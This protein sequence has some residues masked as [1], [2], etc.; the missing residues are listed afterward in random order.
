MGDNNIPDYVTVLYDAS[1]TDFPSVQIPL[2]VTIIYWGL[3][4]VVWVFGFRFGGQFALLPLLLIAIGFHALI[5]IFFRQRQYPA[6]FA[7]RIYVDEKHA[8]L[9][10]AKL[11]RTFYGTFVRSQT[12]L[13]HDLMAIKAKLVNDNV[14]VSFQ[15]GKEPCRILL[16]DKDV[17][18][19]LLLKLKEVRSMPRPDTELS[20]CYS[21]ASTDDEFISDFIQTMA[22][23]GKVTFV[24][25]NGKE[26]EKKKRE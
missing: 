13:I 10:L 26:K 5:Y 15:D 3:V 19:P 14:L 16:L 4:F 20:S 17:A 12:H 23:E 25:E 21:I 24:H 11:Q 8:C 9:T 6:S 2:W 18:K 1:T 22:A 7:K